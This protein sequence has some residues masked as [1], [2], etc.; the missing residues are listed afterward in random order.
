MQH[1]WG[2]ERCIVI[3]C[4]KREGKKTL[5]RPRNVWEENINTDLLEIGWGLNGIDLAQDSGKWQA[6]LNTVMTTQV[7]YLSLTAAR[8]F[9]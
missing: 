4:G 7:F 6:L 9:T 1:V 3:R 5:G 2:E 8:S